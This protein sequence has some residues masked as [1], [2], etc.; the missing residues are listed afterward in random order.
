MNKNEL[1]DAI[2]QE[3][4]GNAKDAKMYLDAFIKVVEETLKQG[5]KS[6]SK[7]SWNITSKEKI[8]FIRAR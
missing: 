1:I 8:S 4:K 7:W 3:T 6:D 2:T 5:K